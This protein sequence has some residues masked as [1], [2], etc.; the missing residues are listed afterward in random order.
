MSSDRPEASQP[1]TSR[2]PQ[3]DRPRGLSHTGGLV[4]SATLA[5]PD[6]AQIFEA[7]TDPLAVVTTDYRLVY[8][9]DAYRRLFGLDVARVA[10]HVCFAAAT[11][12]SSMGAQATPPMPCEQCPLPQTL[13]TGQ[14]A[15]VEQVY[16]VHDTTTG[17]TERRVY[18]RWS[19]PLIS[20]PL[21]PPQS[22]AAPAHGVTAVSADTG[23]ITQIVE[24]LQDISAQERQREEMSQAAARKEAEQLK[25][26][27]LAT[28]SHELRSP[29]T[30]IKGYAATLQ[31]HE[32]RL[33]RAERHE[34]LH[35]IGSASARLEVLINRMLEMAQL[36]SG[37]IQPQYVP[38][39]LA[40][41]VQQ[42]V[43]AARAA[44]SAAVT[45]ASA[46]ESTTLGEVR[47]RLL[48]ALG[49]EL[50]LAAC[51]PIIGDPRLLREVVDH[52]LENA[53]K[54]APAGTPVDVRLRLVDSSST[55]N[56]AEGD[57]FVSTVP[58]PTGASAYEPTTLVRA[59]DKDTG[60]TGDIP[61]PTQHRLELVVQ[62]AGP[63]IPAEHL[64]R[65]FERF[66]QVD[67][68][69]TREVAGL[70][71]GLAICQRIVALHAGTIWAESTPGV[72]SVFHVLLP[73]DPMQAAT[74]RQ[75]E[76]KHVLEKTHDRGGGR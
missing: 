45:E 12:S 35:A 75:T 27:L 33:S 10:G 6:W 16:L 57:D 17:R 72:G 61:H 67:T 55:T 46:E 59:A 69:L 44:A 28:V 47:V 9:N 42:A 39:Q 15:A 48:D 3:S 50:P 63:G 64:G 23:A 26:E 7:I 68:R 18:R 51:P 58:G 37:A 32:R 24:L 60:E 30:S 36:E 41:L 74:S 54:H 49:D 1:R 21:S 13:A 34:F 25:A 29:L 71:L 22:V 5:V 65:I 76:A 62:D 56:A 11:A 8:A 70:G 73:A 66:H 31:R 20:P 38:V 53:R 43:I 52:L 40:E 19:Y 4:P 14:P 2:D